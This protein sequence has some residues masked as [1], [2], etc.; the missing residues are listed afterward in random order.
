MHLEWFVKRKEWLHIN[1]FG[2]IPSY[3]FI[4]QFYIIEIWPGQQCKCQAQYLRVDLSR[5]YLLDIIIALLSV[6]FLYYWDRQ[7]VLALDLSLLINL[8]SSF[9][10][11]NINLRSIQNK[12][13]DFQY[14][15]S[16][17]SKRDIVHVTETWLQDSDIILILIDFSL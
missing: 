10:I 4:E 7:F 2:Y 16:F 12:F 11:I 15:L 14:F 13:L 9:S 17:L 6:F 8:A 3:E 5:K 1:R